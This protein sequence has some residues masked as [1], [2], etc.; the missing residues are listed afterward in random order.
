M[1]MEAIYC[2]AHGLSVLLTGTKDGV[3]HSIIFDT[4]PEEADWE[5]NVRGRMYKAVE[6]ISARK[7]NSPDASQVKLPPLRNLKTLEL[8]S[9]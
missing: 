6:M 1:L 3:K 9:T 5:Q 8:M 4:G 2:G 7:I